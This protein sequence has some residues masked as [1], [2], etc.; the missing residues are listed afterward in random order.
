MDEMVLRARRVG[1]CRRMR[2]SCWVGLKFGLQ[3]LGFESCGMLL[4]GYFEVRSYC[5]PPESQMKCKRSDERIGRKVNPPHTDGA[6]AAGMNDVFCL[7]RSA[8]LA[9]KV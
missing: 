9:P 7:T 4:R 1:G 6:Q 2:C 3:A 5:P 8:V